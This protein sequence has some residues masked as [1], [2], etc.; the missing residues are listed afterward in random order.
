MSRFFTSPL[1][2]GGLTT[3]ILLR[4]FRKASDGPHI[5]TLSHLPTREENLN[6]S[7]TKAVAMAALLLAGSEGAWASLL[8]GDFASDFASWNGATISEDV[9]FDLI[10]TP[11]DPQAHALFTIDAGRGKMTNDDVDFGLILSQQFALDADA[12]SLSFDFSWMVSDSTVDFL[13]AGL[14]HG[15][16]GFID[17]FSSVDLNQD[18]ASGSVSADV[19]S[20]AGQIVTLEFLL[21]DGDLL[22]GDMLLVDNIVVSAQSVP[23]PGTLALAALG[24]VG[25]AGARRRRSRT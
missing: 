24:L 16:G 1:R 10:Q 6:L 17:L 9:N 18:D 22:T 7:N 14:L 23:E 19:S 12:G 21:L 15:V 25:L 20:L 2:G 5:A 13:Q 11:V 4:G 8:N 3:S